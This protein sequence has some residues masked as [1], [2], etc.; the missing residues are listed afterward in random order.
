LKITY[1]KK[2]FYFVLTGLVLGLIVHLLSIA[3]VDVEEFVPFV[4][5]LHIGIFVALILGVI[6][7][8]NNEGLQ[9]FEE[10]EH[11]D[12]F[13]RMKSYNAYL[14]IVFK[15]IPSWMTIIA[16]GVFIYVFLTFVLFFISVVGIPEIKDGHYILQNHGQFIKNITEQEYHHYRAYGMRAMSGIWIV[17]YGLQTAFLYR[18]NGLIKQVRSQS[19]EQREE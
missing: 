14:E 12:F 7:L 8:K 6:N 11:Y 17:F 15:N 5:V 9:E 18:L 10:F 16:K 19:D 2:L 3:D 13:Q 4:Y 1:E